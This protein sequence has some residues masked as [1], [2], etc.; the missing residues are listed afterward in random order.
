VTQRTHPNTIHVT[1]YRPSVADGHLR[2]FCCRQ[3]DDLVWAAACSGIGK[4][5]LAS[6]VVTVAPPGVVVVLLTEYG[7]YAVPLFAQ[8]DEDYQF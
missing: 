1:G 6:L 2:L 4:A 7:C 5:G 8:L 3:L